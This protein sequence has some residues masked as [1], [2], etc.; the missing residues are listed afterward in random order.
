M[1]SK[2]GSLF[3]EPYHI[4]NLCF[5]GIIMLIF[6]YSGIFSAEKNNYP[7]KSACA[8]IEDH[9]C[10]T[11]GLSRSF[12]EIVRFR[13]ESAG[14]YNKYGIKIFLFF[15]IQLFLRVFSSFLLHQKVLPKNYLI[16]I[17]SV[18]SSTLYFYCFLRIIF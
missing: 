5:A 16:L 2:I 17:D 13:F 7:I 8:E 1:T 10:K 14:S 15:L 9:P 18:L 4:I 12:S 11:K 3:R 6:I